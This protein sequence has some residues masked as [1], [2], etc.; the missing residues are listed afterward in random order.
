MKCIGFKNFDYWFMWFELTSWTELFTSLNQV[1]FELKKNS[2]WVRVEL[3]AK[4]NINELSRA[5]PKSTQVNSFSTLLVNNLVFFYHLGIFFLKLPN[6]NTFW[7]NYHLR[8]SHKNT[9]NFVNRIHKSLYDSSYKATSSKTEVRQRFTTF[10][11]Y[12]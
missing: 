12:P 3:R 7:I 8:V 9:Y 10:I 1:K 5:K 2:C 6:G 11:T 4:L